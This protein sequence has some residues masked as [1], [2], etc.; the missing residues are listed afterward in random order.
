M[1]PPPS[2]STDPA[3]DPTPPPETLYTARVFWI[4][5]A[6]LGM[7]SRLLDAATSSW[8]S[9]PASARE[10]YTTAAT[11]MGLPA[12]SASE[13]YATQRVMYAVMAVLI[14]LVALWLTRLVLRGRWWARAVLDVAGA[15]A[16][17]TAVMM[18]AGVFMGLVPDSGRDAVVTFL[19][20]AFQVL[21]GLCA[22]VAL[23]RQHGP[24]AEEFLRG[25]RGRRR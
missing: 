18:G 5:A 8:G 20:M 12:E 13:V 1:Q 3:G 9:L 4:V 19:V 2:G 14:V 24:E 15:F 25:P 6:L 21:S 22:G 17:F 10:P 16:V 23:W 11:G 7:L